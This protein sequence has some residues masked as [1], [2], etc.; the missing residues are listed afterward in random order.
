MQPIL[1][2]IKNGWLAWQQGSSGKKF[3][4]HHRIPR[5]RI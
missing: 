1:F 3:K 2:L 5:V 4:W